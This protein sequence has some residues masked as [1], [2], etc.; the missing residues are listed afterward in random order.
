M[1]LESLKSFIKLAKEEGVAELA[2][3]DGKNK[4]KVV[5][6]GL[7]GG[8]GYVTAPETASPTVSPAAAEQDELITI[9]SPFVGTFYSSATPGAPAFVKV[10]DKIN[11]GKVLCII[12]AMKVMNEIEAEVAGE[13][14]EVCVENEVFVEYGQVLFKVRP[15]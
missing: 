8:T 10:G 13:I 7:R 5:L 9:T 11:P 3:E 1:D 15:A 6:G 12:E 4:M 2:Y 14:V